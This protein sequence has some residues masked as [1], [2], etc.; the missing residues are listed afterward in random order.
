MYGQW[1]EALGPLV[2]FRSPY[3]FRQFKESAHLRNICAIQWSMPL[4]IFAPHSHTYYVQMK[5]SRTTD[6]FVFSA[7]VNGI[8]VH[9]V[10]K[11]F[12]LSFARCLFSHIVSMECI[13]IPL[14]VRTMLLCVHKTLHNWGFFS[15]CL[16]VCAC[17]WTGHLIENIIHSEMLHSQ[18]RKAISAIFH[19]PKK[20]NSQM[21]KHRNA[22]CTP[23][24]CD[25]SRMLNSR[26]GDNRTWNETGRC[27]RERASVRE[28]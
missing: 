17:L 19:P 26:Q 15:L 12:C 18:L 23:C 28:R 11:H 4:V 25:M 10:F 5:S 24:G 21:I 9:A 16:C 22:Y 13:D 20:P 2:S 7:N 6:S 1:Y 27:A 3:E 14:I 8:F